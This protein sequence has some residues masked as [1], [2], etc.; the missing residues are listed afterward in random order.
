MKTILVDKG[1]GRIYQRQVEDIP[2]QLKIK[3]CPSCNKTQPWDILN[4]YADEICPT[5]CMRVPL[6]LPFVQSNMETLKDIY[7]YCNECRQ[8]EVE[9]LIANMEKRTEIQRGQIIGAI[10]AYDEIMRLI[11]SQL[12]HHD[13]GETAEAV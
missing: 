2:T 3:M 10:N 13:C 5:N 12:K 6:P 7:E 11:N 8:A 4:G 1:D 9:D